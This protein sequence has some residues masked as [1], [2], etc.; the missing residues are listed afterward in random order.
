MFFILKTPKKT[1]PTKKKIARDLSGGWGAPERVAQYG[2][3]PKQGGRNKTKHTFGTNH[4]PEQKDASIQG[5]TIQKI[6]MF[7]ED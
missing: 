7:P 4:E 2:R 6:R 3:G 1:P 5:P